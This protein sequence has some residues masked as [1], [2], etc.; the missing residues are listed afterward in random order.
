MSGD[1]EKDFFLPLKDL[2]RE[3]FIRDI[4]TFTFIFILINTQKWYDIFLLIF[5]LVTFGFAMF[6][7]IINLNKWRTEF[8]DTNIIY[9][10]LGL[11]RKH[12]NRLSFSALIQLILLFWLGAESLYNPHIVTGY[13]FYF[14]LLFPFMYSFG[15]FWIFI[16]L[17]DYSKIEII[18]EK[19]TQKQSSKSKSNKPNKKEGKLLSFFNT[20]R[21]RLISI[22]NLLW[23]IT[24]NTLNLLFSIF[25]VSTPS[26]GIPHVLPG[27]GVMGS[28]SLKIPVFFYLLFFGSPFLAASSLFL[29]YREI[30]KFNHEDLTK[31]IKNYPREAQIKII[32]NLKGINTKIKQEMEF[33]S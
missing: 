1:N 25:I 18:F 13:F 24:L 19:E 14:N 33:E 28:E 32:E 26:L 21:A 2:I 22:G 8:D 29:I 31:I 3:S 27:T 23:F 10:P 15:F 4:F 11:E 17:W 30:N 7:R 6:F 16:D 5:P 9:N 12:A 20:Q